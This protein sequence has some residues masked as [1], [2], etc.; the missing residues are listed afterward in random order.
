ML[1]EP[2]PDFLTFYATTATTA[3]W[4]VPKHYTEQIGNDAFKQN[5][6]GLGPY[7]VVRYDPG[8]EIVFEA[9]PDYWRKTPAVQRLVFK[10][11]PE[12]TT[13]LATLKRQEADVTYAIYGPLVEDVQ[14][15]TTLKLAH[16]LAGT[17]WG[18]FVEMYD[19]TSP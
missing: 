3:G 6:V 13:R 19:P 18:S 17:E 14:R 4:I 8:I 2:W 7:R 11:V 1:H 15:D 10:M 5:P 16:T 9:Y 12:P